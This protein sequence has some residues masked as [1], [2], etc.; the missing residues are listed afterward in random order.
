VGHSVS[1]SI[2]LIASLKKPSYFSKHIMVCPSP[3]F[4]NFPP[5]YLGGFEYSDLEEL[6]NLMDKNYIGWAN[7]LAPLV[8]GAESTDL[9]TGELSGSFCSTDPVIAK[10]F[11][12]ATF[13][14][15]Y[16]D[17]FAQVKHPSLIIQNNQ[18]AL[19]ATRVGQYLHQK[20]ADN[21][22][23]I[24]DAQG[25]CPH[26]TPPKLVIDEITS[27]LNNEIFTGIVDATFNKMPCGLIVTD[28]RWKVID[29]NQYILQ[30]VQITPDLF[31]GDS[32]ET[33]FTRGS[34]L[35]CQSIVFPKLLH[36]FSIEE[37]QL[38]LTISSQ[39]CM[40]VV[41]NACCGPETT[42]KVYWTLFP[43][44]ERD[45][46]HQK[47]LDSRDQLEVTNEKL[48]NLSIT[49]ELTGLFNRRELGVSNPV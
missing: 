33:I 45:K 32:I 20:M 34:Q 8:M 4:L 26:M 18:D 19:A 37:I 21:V 46:L 35:L 11:A 13:L 9:L 6:L 22:I 5:E 28:K 38:N 16:R 41:I 43:A 49:D 36:E 47:L 7:Y 3:C 1:C 25:H 23:S 17:H 44:D 24:L 15:D 31:I 29:C 30:K 39:Q 12:K 27:Y 14:S 10:A 48:K 2:G 42:E 40:P